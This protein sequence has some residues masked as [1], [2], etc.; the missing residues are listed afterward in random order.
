VKISGT[1]HV[2]FPKK[3]PLT[4]RVREYETCEIDTAMMWSEGSTRAAVASY[5][6]DPTTY[7]TASDLDRWGRNLLLE[8][9]E[10]PGFRPYVLDEFLFAYLKIKPALPYVS[11]SSPKTQKV[12]RSNRKLA[13]TGG[14]NNP[15]GIPEHVAF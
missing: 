2:F 5:A 8:Y 3:M 14:L 1:D 13:Q 11:L 4:V 10:L 6:I 9:S 12:K 15:S 7:P